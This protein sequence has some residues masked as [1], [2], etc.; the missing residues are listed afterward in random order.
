MTIMMMKMTT[1][2]MMM[3]MMMMMILAADMAVSLGI[4]NRRHQTKSPSI[5]TAFSVFQRRRQIKQETSQS[6]VISVLDR[7]KLEK[8]KVES[9]AEALNARASQVEFW[10]E[11]SQDSPSLA[12]LET[13]GDA[14]AQS[15][16]TADTGFSDILHISP[17]S[18]STYRSYAKF[19]L[20]VRTSL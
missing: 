9:S 18:I 15:I 14:I 17:H 16:Q 11:L 10:K 20:E 6:G 5:D 7:I 2:M 8:S 1:M 13:L 3:M 4:C 19:L 12:R